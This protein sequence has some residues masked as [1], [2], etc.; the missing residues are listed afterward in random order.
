MSSL[1]SETHALARKVAQL[2]ARNRLEQQSQA[3]QPHGHN[4]P[5]SSPHVNWA[6]KRQVKTIS[7]LQEKLRE[8]QDVVGSLESPTKSSNSSRSLPPTND[9]LLAEMQEQ[10]KLQKELHLRRKEL[11]DLMKKDMLEHSELNEQESIRHRRAALEAKGDFSRWLLDVLPGPNQQHMQIPHSPPL[12]RQMSVSSSSFLPETN[13]TEEQIR[14][15]QSQIDTM[16]AD[17]RTLSTCVQQSSVNNKTYN[18][19]HLLLLY[20]RQQQQVQQLTQSVQRC[21]QEIQR[22]DSGLA[23]LQMPSLVA[24]IGF[25]AGGLA[26]TWFILP[27]IL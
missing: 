6:S 5:H 21:F 17:I 24:V 15:L 2:E 4:R 3:P 14:S 10:L 20:H 11:E 18:L 13:S 23:N 22:F 12:S 7:Y 9:R 25:F 1:M 16:L 8:L 19:E 26:A 27:L